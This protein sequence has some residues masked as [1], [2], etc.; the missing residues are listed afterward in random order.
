[1]KKRELKTLNLNRKSVSNLNLTGG[2]SP[3][4]PRSY[5]RTDCVSCYPCQTSVPR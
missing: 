2:S 4:P 5:G 1:M 3:V